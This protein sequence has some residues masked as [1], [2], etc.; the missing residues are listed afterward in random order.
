MLPVLLTDDCVEDVDGEVELVGVDV[1]ELDPDGDC[2]WE[3]PVVGVVD[4]VLPPSGS[5]VLDDEEGRG[6][7]NILRF[8]LGSEVGSGLG[9][10][11][12]DNLVLPSGEP[13]DWFGLGFGLTGDD[14]VDL[15]FGLILTFELK[16]GGFGCCWGIT[17]WGF[18]AGAGVGV[19]FSRGTRIGENGTVLELGEIGG[20]ADWL[21]GGI[22]WLA[23][24][25]TWGV[26][27][28]GAWGIRC[29]SL[30]LS[31]TTF[32]V[33]G[34]GFLPAFSNWV[35][36][37][38]PAPSKACR[39]IEAMI[40]IVVGSMRMSKKLLRLGDWYIFGWNANYQALGSVNEHK[41]KIHSSH[42]RWR[43]LSCG[44]SIPRSPF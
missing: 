32:T 38:N 37:G 11:V 23:G 8:W 15:G 4:E 28:G 40:A 9:N 6:T 2:D 25:N 14:W 12:G 44:E 30:G 24:G 36:K 18:C 42:Q 33:L 31:S 7:V 5:G 39:D 21:V 29:N 34:S 13:D 27:I 26:G 17:C 35:K 41:V 16:L 10:G 1:W 22:G 43:S 19:T 20:A 3:L